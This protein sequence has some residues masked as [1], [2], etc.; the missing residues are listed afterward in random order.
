ML[1]IRA[2]CDGVAVNTKMCQ[3]MQRREAI[4]VPYLGFYLLP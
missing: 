2:S 1:A 4:R 3:D